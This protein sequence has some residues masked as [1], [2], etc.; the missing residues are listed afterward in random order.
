[1]PPK[2]D[3]LDAENI[4][5]ISTIRKMLYNKPKELEMFKFLIIHCNNYLNDKRLDEEIESMELETEDT[6]WEKN[7]ITDSDTESDMED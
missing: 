2:I 5:E 1:M 6:D 4:I 7:L 3:K